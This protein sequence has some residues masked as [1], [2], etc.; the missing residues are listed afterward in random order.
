MTPA[1]LEDVTSGCLNGAKCTASA[2]INNGWKMKMN[3]PWQDSSL[4]CGAKV[5]APAFTAAAEVFFP[6]YQ[7]AN[8]LAGSECKPSEGDSYLYTVNLWDATATRDYDSTTA[9][10]T[11]ADIYSSTSSP[12]IGAETTY[13]GGNQILN[14][15]GGGGGSPEKVDIKGGYRSYWHRNASQ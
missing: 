11:L 8:G 15:A 6:A 5:L 9:G 13:L 10:L 2:N 12:G 4:P 7:P 1:A 14:S 3:C